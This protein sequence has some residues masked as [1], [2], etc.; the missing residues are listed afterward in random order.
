VKPDTARTGENEG[1][2][3]RAPRLENGNYGKQIVKGL[4]LP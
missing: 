4:L 3:G 2:Q 1:A